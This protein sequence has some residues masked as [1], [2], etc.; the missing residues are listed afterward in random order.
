MCWIESFQVHIYS[1]KKTE[2]NYNTATSIF[3]SHDGYC[4][5]SSEVSLQFSALAP[6]KSRKWKRKHQ[7]W[8]Q[9]K[10][11]QGWAQGKKKKPEVK[12]LGDYCWRKYNIIHPK[13]PEFRLKPEIAHPQ[14]IFGYWNIIPK[15][16]KKTQIIDPVA[17]CRIAQLVERQTYR[18]RIKGW[19]G[20]GLRSDFILCVA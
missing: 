8:A 7:G 17:A 19:F 18:V 14:N 2:S 12:I 13:K 4:S 15:D 9:V 20:Y 11:N 3:G 5:L 1:P 10:K 6:D 16:K